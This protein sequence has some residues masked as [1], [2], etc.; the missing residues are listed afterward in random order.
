MKTFRITENEL[1]LLA[2]LCAAFRVTLRSYRGEA[3]EPDEASALEELTEYHNNGWPIFAAEEGGRIVGYTV[4]RIENELVWVEQL[5]VLPEMRR[6]GAASMLFD[7]AEAVARSFG[8][9]TVFN[10]IHPNNEG[11][12]AFLASR[13]Y[14]V[15]NLIEIRKPWPGET[16][17]TK[18][19]VNGHEFDY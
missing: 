9:E 19:S 14:T 18:I 4:C 2:P 11:V 16:P 15:L 10:Y 12:I 6:R 1:P 13:G 17:K 7:E 5:F 8:E 3:S